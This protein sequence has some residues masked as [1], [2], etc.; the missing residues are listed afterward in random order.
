VLGHDLRNPL[1]TILTAAQLLEHQSHD[2][3]VKKVSGGMVSSA[4]R[5]SRMIEDLLDLARA[6]LAGGIPL[7]RERTDLA[8]LVRRVVHECQQGFPDRRIEGT[9]EGDIVGEWDADRLSQ[10]VSNLIGNAVQHGDPAGPVEVRLQTIPSD[11]VLLSVTNSGCIPSELLPHVFDP[12]RGGRRPLTRSEG[13]GLGLY[14]VQQ[15]V[16]AHGGSVEV[17]SDA[18]HTAFQVRMPRQSVEIVR[19]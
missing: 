5:M 6:R 13:L 8:A 18:T 19:L 17:Q 15:I 3:L 2:D 7:R 10:V 12:F 11:D 16:M 14:I 4:R 9:F 1:N